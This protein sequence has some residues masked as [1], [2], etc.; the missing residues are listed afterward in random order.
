MIVR[1]SPAAL[2]GALAAPPSK[3]LGHRALL[4][5]GLAAGE[6]TLLGI[7]DSQD[8]LATREGL[9]AL[10]A[11]TTRLAD[12]SLRVRGAGFPR[13]FS[14][15]RSVFCRESGSTLRFLIPL[16]ALSSQETVFTGSPRLMQRSQSVYEE[17]FAA[18][19]LPFVRENGTLR[20]RGPLK[21]GELRLRGDIS[22]QFL[23]GLLLALPLLEEDSALC[24]TPPFSSRAYVDLTMQM[25]SR[26]HVRAGFSGEYRLEIPGRQRYTA[27]DLAVEGDY[28][29]AA[30]FAVAGAVQGNVRL[31][32][33]DPGSLQGDKAILSILSACGAR[34]FPEPDGLRFAAA[35]ALMAQEIDVDPIPDLMPI[36]SVLAL[37]CRGQTRLMNAARLR[38]KESD[39]LAAMEEE[40][41][42]LHCRVA[43]TRDSMA[44][45]GFL[46]AYGETEMDCH[47]DHRVAMSLAILATLGPSPLILHGAQAVDKSYPAFFRH[48]QALGGRVE[49]LEA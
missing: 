6:S 10:G 27:R 2:S 4:C 26:F 48:L 36:L 45:E 14:A 31:T 43:S 25:L 38:D 30:F 7:P 23:T 28:S 41:R 42:R 18:Q 19:G 5:A 35:P 49:V 3:S 15:P 9:S 37:F 34:L 20:L 32:N 44:I 12:G 21:G 16:F 29:Q 46:P 24:V 11:Q 47:N 1:I 33:L 40:L 22:S 8:M 17:L 39:R 13:E